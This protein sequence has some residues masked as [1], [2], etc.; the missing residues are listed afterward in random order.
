M[1]RSKTILQSKYPYH[2]GARCIN[3]EWFTLPMEVVWRVM[4]DH[5]FWVHHA[6][7]AEI[8]AFV[9]MQNHFHLIIST[10]QFN[11]SKVM[12]YFMRATSLEFSRLTRRTNQWYGGRHFRCVIT[13]PQY[14]L[15]AYKYVYRNPVK[16]GLVER[17]EDYPFST[18]SGLLGLRHFYI[19][20]VEDLTLSSNVEEV[21]IWLNQ[22]PKD[23]DE[24]A[25]RRAL[26]KREFVLAKTNSNKCS[27]LEF[28][29]F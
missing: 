4:S 24:Q 26:R 5:L 29:A 25:V 17:V 14:Y 21:L 12:A 19:P 8:H 16:A 27:K 18:L 10:P 28:D 2:V 15:H 6:F 1:P 20:L 9:L 11:L 3:K 23:Q 7:G 22:A 13:K